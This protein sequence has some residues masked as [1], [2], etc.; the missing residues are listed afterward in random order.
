MSTTRKKNSKTVEAPAKKKHDDGIRETFD[1]IVFAFVLAFLFRAFAAEAFII[2]TGSMA[3]TLLGRNKD[4]YCSQCDYEFTI[5]ASSEVDS[6]SGR[7]QARLNWATCPNCRYDIN[8]R[9]DNVYNGDRILVTKFSYEFADPDRFDVIVFK[10]PES[11]NTS[12]IKRLIGLPGE[13]IKI[14]QGDIYTRKSN[15]DPWAIARKANPDKQQDIQ[16]SVYDNNY[17]ATPLHQA[18]WPLRW[19]GM[20]QQSGKDELDGWVESTTG[21]QTIDGGAAYQLDGT[22]SDETAWLRYRHIVPSSRDWDDLETGRPL[23]QNPVPQLVLDF[24]SYNTTSFDQGRGGEVPNPARY[25]VGDLTLSFN[26][27]LR[28]AGNS[29]ELLVEL[30]EG[31][32]QYRC[33]FDLQTGQVQAQMIDHFL[34]DPEPRALGT[35]DSGVIAGDEYDIRFANVDNRLVLWVN[36][37]VVTF[38]QPLTY[39]TP[40]FPGPRE[41]D[42]VPAGI[43]AR[44]VNVVVSDLKIQRDIYYRAEASHDNRGTPLDPSITGM[45]ENDSTNL[46]T[47]RTDPE[48]WWK[49][50]INNSDDYSLV[51]APLADDEYFVMGDNSP[52]SK[53]SRLWEND[54]AAKNRHAVKE[55][56]LVGKAFYIFWPHGVPVGNDGKGFPI[57]YHRDN[58]NNKTDYPTYSLPFLPQLDKMKR[59]R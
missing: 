45:G 49:I 41:R 18:G 31:V 24:C 13:S 23:V 55:S 22:N 16:L 58:L 21:W 20:Q 51:F 57:R 53:D 39:D 33:Q 46:Y 30:N 44:E 2:P 40:G 34:A 37:S 14:E 4:V 15:Q 36:D 29:P 19:T 42:L 48:T 54:R 17:R 50:Y 25:W 6:E 26:A 9:D 3:P 47:H 35:A 12:Y 43:A 32:R 5:G 1:S 11:P 7:L 8:V 56:A 28:D 38:D 52:R 10:Y 27:D 59:I